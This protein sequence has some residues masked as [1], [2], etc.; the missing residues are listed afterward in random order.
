MT[1]DKLKHLLDDLAWKLYVASRLWPEELT[2]N[3]TDLMLAPDSRP[4]GRAVVI[5][6]KASQNRTAPPSPRVNDK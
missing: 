1:K 4:A 2:R 3:M 6:Y 5:R